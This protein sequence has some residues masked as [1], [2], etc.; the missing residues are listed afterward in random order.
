MSL[1]ENI[2]YRLRLAVVPAVLLALLGYFA[3][4]AVSGNH[5]LLALKELEREHDLIQA[6]A[7]VTATE[8]SRLEARVA[9]LRPDNLDPDLLDERAR[10]ALGFTERGEMVIFLSKK[11]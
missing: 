1:I 8:R 6:R 2:Q 4:H 7:E 11:P 3:Y 10:A 5:G 9:R